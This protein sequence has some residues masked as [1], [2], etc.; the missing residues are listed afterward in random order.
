LEFDIGFLLD[1]HFFHR[2]RARA[3]A[4]LA[5]APVPHRR[6]RIPDPATALS[7]ATEQAAGYGI[8]YARDGIVKA[9]HGRETLKTRAT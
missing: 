7:W 6:E 5:S 4:S 3:F 9:P 1:V 8:W 2:Q